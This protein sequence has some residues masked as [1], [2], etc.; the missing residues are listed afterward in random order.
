M[1]KQR[2]PI[3][4]GLHVQGS[5][6]HIPGKTWLIADLLMQ[7]SVNFQKRQDGVIRHN[8]LW[9]GSLTDVFLLLLLLPPWRAIAEKRKKRGGGP[10][11]TSMNYRQSQTTKPLNE[12]S[13][14]TKICLLCIPKLPPWQKVNPPR[15][16]PTFWSQIQRGLGVNWQQLRQVSPTTSKVLIR[17][18]ASAAWKR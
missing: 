1:L 4:C 11:L 10:G 13:D 14:V 3:P 17:Q 12:K 16:A 15:F 18:L 5:F 2:S 8:E 7:S 6:F 9:I